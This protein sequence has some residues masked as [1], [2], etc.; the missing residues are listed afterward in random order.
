MPVRLLA[1]KQAASYCACAV[2][3]IRQ[4]IWSKELTACTIGRPFLIEI[5]SLDSF[6]DAKFKEQAA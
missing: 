6:I 5:T 4:V 1:I 3:A 2:W